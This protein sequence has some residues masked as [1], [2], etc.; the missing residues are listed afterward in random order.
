M[1]E[2]RGEERLIGMGVKHHSDE[3][4][5]VVMEDSS[6]FDVSGGD[7]LHVPELHAA[8]KHNGKEDLNS[9]KRC[10]G[11]DHLHALANLGQSQFTIGFFQLS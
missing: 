4:E 9:L 5:V 6:V 3:M 7:N 2:E 10:E 1:T 11:V 8:A